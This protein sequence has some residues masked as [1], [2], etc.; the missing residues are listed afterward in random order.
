MDLAELEKAAIAAKNEYFLYKNAIQDY[1]DRLAE[2]QTEM[3][4]THAEHLK[5]YY[6]AQVASKMPKPMAIKSATNQVR[7]MCAE[8]LAVTNPIGAISVKDPRTVAK[9]RNLIPDLRDTLES[10][11][12]IKKTLEVLA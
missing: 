11:M 8:I 6:A 9:Y 4:L 12:F 7:Q 10:I 5:A 2:L 1:L 3:D